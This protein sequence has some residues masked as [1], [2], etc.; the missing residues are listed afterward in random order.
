MRA[1]EESAEVIVVKNA[2][3]KLGRSEGPKNQEK[4]LSEP[5]GGKTARR[6]T[7]QHTGAANPGKP[8]ELMETES[9]VDSSQRR[10][11]HVHRVGP[12]T[13]GGKDEA[14]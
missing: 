10:H 7:K 9:E 6:R 14:Q 11:A 2:P 1:A 5:S 4:A 8:P 3:G 13:K 12:A